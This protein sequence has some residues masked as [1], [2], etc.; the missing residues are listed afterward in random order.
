[1]NKQTL[2]TAVLGLNSDGQMLL[3]AALDNQYFELVA[4]ADKNTLLAE[5]IGREVD[6]K[7]FDD[8]RQLIIGNQLDCL[9]VAAGL[10]S[11][12]EYIRQAIKK[13]FNILKIPPAARRFE[14][15][16]ELVKLAEDNG[17]QIMVANEKR[18]SDSFPAFRD[19]LQHVQVRELSSS[20]SE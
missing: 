14:E 9:I 13:K 5:Q 7:A 2:K 10:Y 17:T 20:Y 19:Y 6:C 18:F 15:A 8:Y 1:M 16:A 4:V 11:C 12:E 3:K